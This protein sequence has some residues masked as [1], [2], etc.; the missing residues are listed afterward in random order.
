M[1]SIKIE[2][3][4]KSYELTFTRKTVMQ[5]EKLGLNLEKA[6][7]TPITTVLTLGYGAFLAKQPNIKRELAED[8]VLSCEDREGLFDALMNLYIIPL[9]SLVDDSNKTKNAKWEAVI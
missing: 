8:I 5:T 7:E 4:G 2:Y 3:E 6:E 9:N 1:K